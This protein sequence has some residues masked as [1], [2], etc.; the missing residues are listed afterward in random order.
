MFF[1]CVLQVDCCRHSLFFPDL[2]SL[3]VGL[4]TITDDPDVELMHVKNRLSPSHDVR[5]T[6]GYRDVLV[7]LRLRTA[8]ARRLN[9]D[10]HVWELQL[11]LVSFARIKVRF[12]VW[13]AVLHSLGRRRRPSGE[14]SALFP[15]SIV[16]DSF[17]T[18]P[19][20]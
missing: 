19:C 14:N 8:E 2:A 5:I 13:A 1:A 7:N 3:I 4:R 10:H 15:C 12:A 9:L 11:M 17:P 6:A 16:N 18:R 20:Q